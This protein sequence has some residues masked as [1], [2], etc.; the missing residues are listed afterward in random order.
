MASIDSIPKDTSK[1]SD[2]IDAPLFVN[3][4]DH[5][6]GENENENE[7]ENQN[8]IKETTA[9]KNNSTQIENEIENEI[10]LFS[11]IHQEIPLLQKP[12]NDDTQPEIPSTSKKSIEV[13]S[14]LPLK[15]QQR[16]LEDLLVNDALLILG[17]GLGIESI[18]AN[19]LHILS[20]PQSKQKKSLVILL[21]ANDYENE[22][23]AQELIE[24]SWIDFLNNESNDTTTT[25]TTN[26]NN[27]NENRILSN[28]S[29]SFKIIS[30]ESITVNKRKKIYLNGGI[31]S[32]TS[33]I[34]VV[35]LLSEIIDP[36]LITGLIFLHPETISEISN[37]SFIINLY[38]SKNKWGFIKALCDSPRYLL[39]TGLNDKTGG[40]LNPLQIMLRNMNLK[41]CLLW[42]RFHVEVS[43][44][45][46][47]INRKNKNFKK[48]KKH[49]ITQS[50]NEIEKEK[51]NEKFGYITEIKI[52]M[53]E[54][55]KQIQVAILSCIEACVN[56]IKRHNPTL[57]AISLKEDQ[58][59]LFLDD[60]FLSRLHG[61]FDTNWHRISWTS[62]RLILDLRVLRGLLES[63]INDDCVDF[64]SNFKMIINEDKSNAGSSFNYKG[65]LWLTLDE[66]IRIDSFA[67]KRVFEIINDPFSDS[68]DAK[69]YLLEEL[70]KWEQLAIVLDDIF[71]ERSLHPNS[72][73]NQGPTLVMCSRRSYRQIK[74]FL[75]TMKRFKGFDDDSS[76]YDKQEIEQNKAVERFNS[77]GFERNQVNNNNS[78]NSSNNLDVSQTFNKKLQPTSKR[79]RT[80]GGS[81]IAQ[82]ER[83]HTASDVSSKN[84]DDLEI[85]ESVDNIN[86]QGGFFK[87]EKTNTID[88]FEYLERGEQ[89]FVQYFDENTDELL[90]Q[91]LLPSYVVMY[92]PNL[93]FFRRLEVH[94]A[95][96][97]A[98][99]PVK[100]FLLYYQNSTEEQRHLTRIRKE[101]E[102][103]M[104]L[105]K[106][107]A[108]LGKEFETEND[109]R[110]KFEIKKTEVTLNTRVAGGAGS[111]AFKNPDEK[112]VV[113][114]DMREFNSALPNLLYRIGL[115]V[116]P[117]QITVGDYILSPKICVERKSIPDL[118][119]SLKNGRLYQQCEQM[120]RYYET[121]IL[122]IEFSEKQSFS[123]EPF[124]EYHSRSSLSGSQNTNPQSSKKMISQIQIK[125]SML[126]LAFPKLKI[127][128]SPSP[129]KT[130]EIIV[131]LKAKQKEPDIDQAINAGLDP[132]MK[133]SMSS[134]MT[135][136]Q[137]NDS[138]VDV[139][140]CI[141]GVTAAN[142]YSVIRKVKNLQ[143]LVL[144][145]QEELAELVGKEAAHQAYSFIHQKMDSG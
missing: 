88:D 13:S 97:K 61:L 68:N 136:V 47:L 8:Q 6:I 100:T 25:T 76:G 99:N 56:E 89:V 41:K 44:S 137:I 23:I 51:E 26:N 57:T 46:N 71:T 138:A 142:L 83:L 31:I 132:I 34:F 130:A 62:K 30:G 11:K 53:T 74:K 110:R 116:I 10:N 103:F 93:S 121:V 79:R 77:S 18:T 128:W 9:L 40:N 4:S 49:F 32:A 52:E 95:I 19:L 125:L 107:K 111:R 109:S 16:I 131:E 33:R 5:D 78:N 141:P 87:R 70:P 36:N 85:I 48:G 124:A 120:F 12:P 28:L 123:M 27:N 135:S 29:S 15:F 20:V 84:I 134:D 66:A 113:I 65:S 101:K 108:S 64:Y 54:S 105:I 55:M 67:K 143:E 7:N 90:L 104:K 115:K 60:F 22:K 1:A 35:D 59:A 37:E 21:N 127:I 106:E 94:Q 119:G 114:V 102:S 145:K 126:L 81:Y 86:D 39:N 3:D 117:C 91:E 82:V 42:P 69:S 14:T 63:L 133:Q 144:L 92:E 112:S 38:H 58:I 118:T 72:S 75:S 140:R 45:L 17:K 98:T 129:Y 122:L 2:P 24:L 43:K 50:Q 73:T 96:Y 139:L 80:R